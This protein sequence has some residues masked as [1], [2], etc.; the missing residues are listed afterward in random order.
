MNTGLADVADG[1]TMECDKGDE[2][3]VTVDEEEGTVTAGQG[4]R[5]NFLEFFLQNCYYSF[6]RG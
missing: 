6:Q 4:T 5:M 2:G 1:T 3:T